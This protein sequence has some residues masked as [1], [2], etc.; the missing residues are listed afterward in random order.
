IWINPVMSGLSPLLHSEIFKAVD[1]VRQAD[2]KATWM[3]YYGLELSEL[4]RA[5]GANVIGSTKIV[6]DLEFMHRIDPENQGTFIY[7]RYAHVLCHLPKSRGEMAFSLIENDLYLMEIDPSLP[8]MEDI[9]IRY[10]VF[11]NEW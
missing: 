2:P 5:T 6:P 7:N 9:G 11:P 8:I 1:Q 4:V 10:I 3:V